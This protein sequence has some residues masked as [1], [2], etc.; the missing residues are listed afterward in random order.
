MFVTWY[1]YILEINYTVN[2]DVQPGDRTIIYTQRFFF[3]L[4]SVTYMISVNICLKSLNEISRPKKNYFIHE[5][6]E[7]NYGSL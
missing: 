5:L 3:P 7:G 6:F 2:S 4:R 1:I